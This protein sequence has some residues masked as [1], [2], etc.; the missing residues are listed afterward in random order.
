MDAHYTVQST[1]AG[2]Q[3]F[4]KAGGGKKGG[5]SIN[6]QFSAGLEQLLRGLGRRRI[7][8]G[9]IAIDT[10]QTRDKW[11]LEERTLAFAYPVDLAAERDYRKLRNR[12]TGLERKR[13]KPKSS[14]TSQLLLELLATDPNID[15]AA[16][17]MSLGTDADFD[18]TADELVLRE[19]AERYRRRASDVEIPAGI[20]RP[21]ATTAQS[22]QFVRDPR[23]R[24]WVERQADGNCELCGERTF[25]RPDGSWYIE[26]H[27][28]VPLAEG[29][30]D[31]VENA[32]ALCPSCHRAC[33]HASDSLHRTE[34]LYARIQRLRRGGGGERRKG[35]TS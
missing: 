23:V 18:P 24:G 9:R 17:A 16:E 7:L 32:V 1:G 19:R 31:T 12:I 5:G 25:T 29:G 6:R 27:H 33:H 13:L 14:Y 3:L 15:V 22:Q 30:S 28:V 26:V 20:D 35:D 8:L 34:A 21:L 11:T 4:F 10:S 2:V